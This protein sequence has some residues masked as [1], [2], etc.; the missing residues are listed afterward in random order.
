MKVIV[1]VIFSTLFLM[2]CSNYGQ[3]SLVAELPNRL[4]EVSGTEI[5]TNSKDIWMLNDSGNKSELYAVNTKGKI[6]RTL[7]LK[8]KNNDWEDLTSD[9]KGNLY[10][11][12][13]GNNENHR[14]DLVILKVKKKDL[15]KDKKVTVDKIKFSYP[16]Q[17]HFPPKKEARFFDSEAMFYWNDFL[18]VFTKSRVEGNYGKTDLYKV[19]AKKGTYIA[20]YIAS[21]TTC[22][23]SVS[24]WVT[25]ASISPDQSKVVLLNHHAIFVFTKFTSDNFFEGNVKVYD[26]EHTSQKEAIDFKNNTTLYITDEKAHGTGG[27]LYEFTIND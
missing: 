5:S 6:K 20:E 8:A 22:N 2:S 1:T 4:E 12:D 25:S 13:F 10:V 27:H 23:N 7:K 14:K 18:Y 17:H 11:G 3:L 16:N 24:C 15:D 9:E 19:P 26:L 21:Y